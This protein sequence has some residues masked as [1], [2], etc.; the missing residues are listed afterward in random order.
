MTAAKVIEEIKTLSPQQQ[1][2]VIR[3]TFRVASTRPLTS[4]ELSVLATRIVESTDPDEVQ[5]LKSVITR[6]FYPNAN[7]N[8]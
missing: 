6:R 4:A 1:L 3:F 7:H 5:R 8:E 2:E